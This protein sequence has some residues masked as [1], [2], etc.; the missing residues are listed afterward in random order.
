M[1]SLGFHAHLHQQ[2]D[3]AEACRVNGGML[4]LKGKAR[5]KQLAPTM[6]YTSR[7][8]SEACIKSWRHPQ[9]LETNALPV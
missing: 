9:T 8:D 4:Q 3:P 6:Q 5:S 7:Y 2:C 1:F